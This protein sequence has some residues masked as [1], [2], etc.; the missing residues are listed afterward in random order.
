MFAEVA[1]DVSGGEVKVAPEIEWG[2]SLARLR[3]CEVEELDVRRNV[4]REALTACRFNMSPQHLPWIASEGRA[5]KVVYVAE[6]SRFGSILVAKWKNLKRVRI[7][8]GEYV[9]FLNP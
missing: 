3:R 1:S 2:W 8:N 6:H 9:R 7:W 4:K 5:I